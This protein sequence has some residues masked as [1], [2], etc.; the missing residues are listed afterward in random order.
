MALSVAQVTTPLT[1]GRPDGDNPVMRFLGPL[2][3]GMEPTALDGVKTTNFDLTENYRGKNVQIR[4]VIEGL[5]MDNPND[6]LTT[7]ALPWARTDQMHFTWNE[8]RF[9]TPLIDRVPHEGI[10]RML[11]SSKVVRNAH[12]VRRGIAFQMEGDYYNSPDGDRQFLL[13]VRQ[14]TKAVQ[15]PYHAA[16]RPRPS[17]AC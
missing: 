15:G 9:D 10:S 17:T 12:V 3:P 4:T 8:W 1:V 2:I 5:L 11:Q 13:N 16:Y 7:V 14:I 6:F